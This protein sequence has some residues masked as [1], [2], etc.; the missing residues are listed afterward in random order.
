VRRVGR[1]IC[2]VAQAGAISIGL[3]QLAIEDAF[4][5]RGKGRIALGAWP[6]QRDAQAPAREP[7]E[8]GRH[9]R[10]QRRLVQAGL[11]GHEKLETNTAQARW[12]SVSRH[13]LGRLRAGAPRQEGKGMRGLRGGGRA[14]ARAGSS[15]ARRRILKGNDA[16]RNDGNCGWLYGKQR[17]SRLRATANTSHALTRFGPSVPSRQTHTHTQTQHCGQAS[18]SPP[19]SHRGVFERLGSPCGQ[20]AYGLGGCQPKLRASRIAR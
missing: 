10:G 17:T 14:V 1:P 7:V 8:R 4:V 5:D 15:R 18:M 2:R 19:G 3:S 20:R 9:V 12:R 16:K 13:V 6:G 11:H